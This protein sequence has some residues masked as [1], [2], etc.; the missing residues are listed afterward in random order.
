MSILL[1]LYFSFF[2]GQTDAP[3]EEIPSEQ[4]ELPIIEQTTPSLNPVQENATSDSIIDAPT[5]VDMSSAVAEV[6][7]EIIEVEN[8]NLKITFSSIGGKIKEV[9]IKDYVTY[10]KE[11]LIL[12]DEQ[13]SKFSLLANNSGNQVDLMQQPYQINKSTKADTTIITFTMTNASGGIF[14]QIY[15]IADAGYEVAYSIR[16]EGMDHLLG[17]DLSFNWQNNLKS[18]EKDPVTSRI[19]TSVYY[20][21]LD[22]SL[23]ELGERPAQCFTCARRA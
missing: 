22:G 3:L 14:E 13:S 23:E 18:F 11:P 10:T 1:L 7:E 8:E 12:L 9:L 17:S 6:K 16:A 20:Y 19:K 15:K 2:G 4:V 21:T 5:Q